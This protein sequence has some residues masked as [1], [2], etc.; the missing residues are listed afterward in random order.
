VI[1]IIGIL[2]ALLLPAVQAARE[3]ARR[4]QCS[5]NMKQLSLAMHNYHDVHKVFA[6]GW[7]TPLT[8]PRNTNYWGWVAII[9][10]FVEQTALYDA[11][12]VGVQDHIPPANT[13][14]NGRLLLQQPVPTYVCPSDDGPAINP[15][16]QNPRNVGYAKNNYMSTRFVAWGPGDDPPSGFRDITDGTSNTFMIGERRQTNGVKFINGGNQWGRVQFGVNSDS[17]MIFHA[18]WPPNTPT[19]MTSVNGTPDVYCK[20]MALSSNHP[21]GVQFAFTDGSVKFISQTIAS[22]PL[23]VRQFQGCSNGS[24]ARNDPRVPKGGCAGVPGAIYQ[25]LYD[26]QDGAVVENNF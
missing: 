9:L 18:S 24:A 6:M 4:M 22:N 13:V 11:V 17:A 5:N 16:Y 19:E 14:F 20:R 8:N 23:C 10:P 15:F 12:G 26:S 2:V 3:A 25:N 7:V 21:G 1:A